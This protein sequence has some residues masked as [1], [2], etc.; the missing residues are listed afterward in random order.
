MH[1]GSWSQNVERKSYVNY[2]IKYNNF[3]SVKTAICLPKSFRLQISHSF[4]IPKLLVQDPQGS[5]ITHTDAKIIFTTYH[6][7]TDLIK[8]TLN[9]DGNNVILLC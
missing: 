6:T 4:S 2:A 9:T 7:R 8:A 5:H 1:P 3:N